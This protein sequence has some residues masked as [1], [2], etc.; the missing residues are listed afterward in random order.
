[1]NSV[2]YIAKDLSYTNCQEHE[3][4]RGRTNCHGKPCSKPV[5]VPM[6]SKQ[7]W[8][9][10]VAGFLELSSLD[11]NNPHAL[12]KFVMSGLPHVA[13]I[14]R[15]S[16]RTSY[17]LASSLDYWR[18]AWVPSVVEQMHGL[19]G[20]DLQLEL[21]P[22]E[23][24]ELQKSI[25]KRPHRTLGNLPKMIRSFHQHQL[26]DK[27]TA[28]SLVEYTWRGGPATMSSYHTLAEAI[29]VELLD[30]HP[31]RLSTRERKSEGL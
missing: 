20:V 8:Y 4:G 7:F 3:A 22:H 2:K 5:K 12:R 23:A 10:A 1:V 27:L 28:V 24:R 30:Y 14:R 31:R 29:K 18:T 25:M 13:C 11:F 15:I 19:R 17:G 21:Q 9:E 16:I 6:V 26:N